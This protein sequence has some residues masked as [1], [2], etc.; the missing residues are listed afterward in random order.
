MENYFT[1]NIQLIIILLIASYQTNTTKATLLANNKE[2]NITIIILS[3]E[4]KNYLS[5]LFANKLFIIML[6]Y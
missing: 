5:K 6:F 3:T 4:L 2:N 1:A